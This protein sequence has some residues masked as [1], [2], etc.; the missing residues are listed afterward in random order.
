MSIKVAQND[1]TRKMNDTITKLPNNVCN[2]GKIIVAINR[3][4]WSHWFQLGIELILAPTLLD[5]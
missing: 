3:P 2:L 4:I 1:F 5:K